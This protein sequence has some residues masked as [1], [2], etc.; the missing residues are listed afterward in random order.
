MTGSGGLAAP[1][2][3][4]RPRLR[5]PREARREGVAVP[6]GRL[7]FPER[8]AL[9]VPGSDGGR[10]A[11]CAGARFMRTLPRISCVGDVLLVTVPLEV[12]LSS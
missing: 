8:W 1:G 7:P 4:L 2:Y 9:D 11:R 12:V 3:H 6:A 5:E 10:S